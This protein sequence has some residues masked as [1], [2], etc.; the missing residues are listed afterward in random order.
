MNPKPTVAKLDVLRGVLP[1]WLPQRT[2][3]ART[4]SASM[5][6]PNG[7]RAFASSPYLP[8]AA[9]FL[10]TTARPFS[11]ADESDDPLPEVACHDADGLRAEDMLWELQH[12]CL[13]L[14]QHCQIITRH[15]HDR[16]TVRVADFAKLEPQ[17]DPCLV[18]AAQ[19]L[20]QREKSLTH[21]TFRLVED[22]SRE[23]A[24]L[25]LS[26]ASSSRLHRFDGGRL[27]SQVLS[28]MH[29]LSQL[30]TNRQET[31]TEGTR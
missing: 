19:D 24:D 3:E 27:R 2:Q 10:A 15:H 6:M 20:G 30:D 18:S 31:D 1:V 13:Y 12:I 4:W 25:I 21:G 26:L 16:I 5:T 22:A 14:A 8:R 29:W 23:G 17:I 11:I 28:V 9:E 7:L